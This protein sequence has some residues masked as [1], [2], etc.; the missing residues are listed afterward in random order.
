MRMHTWTLNCKDINDTNTMVVV[1]LVCDINENKEVV[2]DDNVTYD[3]TEHRVDEDQ[4]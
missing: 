3:Y 4:I 2:Y 1:E